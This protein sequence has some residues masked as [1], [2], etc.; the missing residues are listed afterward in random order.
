M[1]TLAEFI[2]EAHARQALLTEA[3]TNGIEDEIDGCQQSVEEWNAVL[4]HVL[5]NNMSRLLDVAGDLDMGA[6]PAGYGMTYSKPGNWVD[7]EPPS[8]GPTP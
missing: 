6:V 2:A 8:S 7:G 3:R 4:Q 1:A 5:S